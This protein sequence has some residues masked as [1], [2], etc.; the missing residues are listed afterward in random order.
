VPLR[1]QDFWRDQNNPEKPRVTQIH[2]QRITTEWRA[3]GYIS[4]LKQIVTLRP[5]HF[6]PPPKLNQFVSCI[7]RFEFFGPVA[8]PE[9]FQVSV[10]QNTV[11]AQRAPLAPRKPRSRND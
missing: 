4:D 5:R 9:R 7:V 2:V 11:S 1:I 6:S 3:E 10:P 8:V